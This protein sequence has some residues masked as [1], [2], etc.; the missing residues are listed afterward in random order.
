MFGGGGA[1]I[2]TK[3]WHRLFLSLTDLDFMNDEINMKICASFRASELTLLH[4]LV[5]W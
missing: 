2:N 5:H 1:G 3:M 4:L